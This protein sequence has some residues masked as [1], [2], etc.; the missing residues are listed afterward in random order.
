[1]PRCTQRQRSAKSL[2]LTEMFQAMFQASYDQ[3]CAKCGSK[4]V[5]QSDSCTISKNLSS[6]CKSVARIQRK[7]EINPRKPPNATVVNASNGGA[8]LSG[9]MRVKSSS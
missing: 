1:M 6:C 7:L 3:T 4:S 5:I 8:L 2:N 9:S